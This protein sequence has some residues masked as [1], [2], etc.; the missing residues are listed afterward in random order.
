MKKLFCFHKWPEEPYRE[1]SLHDYEKGA[2]VTK[3]EK[4]AF[5]LLKKSEISDGYVCTYECTKCGKKDV[6]VQIPADDFENI[7]KEVTERE[8]EEEGIKATID[9]IKAENEETRKKNAALLKKIEEAKK[10]NK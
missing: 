4:K 6:R 7:G 5:L 10:R 1:I 2:K 3:Q 9:A 8:L